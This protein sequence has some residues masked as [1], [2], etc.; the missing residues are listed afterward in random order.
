M[1]I[2]Q[3]IIQ[4]MVREFFKQWLLAGKFFQQRSGRTSSARFIEQQRLC[5]LVR[6]RF[7]EQ[8]RLYLC[9]SSGVIEQQQRLLACKQLL[10]RLLACK[11]LLQ[12]LVQVRFRQPV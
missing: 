2:Q 3:R 6:A 9:T 10:Q 11:Q 5:I 4:R 7:I 1:G 8:Q 12:R